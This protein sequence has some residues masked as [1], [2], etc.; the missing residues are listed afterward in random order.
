M[1]SGLGVFGGRGRCHPFWTDFSECMSKADVPSDCKEMR[2]DYFECLHHRK[3]FIGTVKH[4]RVADYK[5]PHPPKGPIVLQDH[6]NPMR[7][8]NIWI[9]HIGDYDEG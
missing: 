2:E 4:K 7:F 9:R 1:A 6:G 8:R 5:S 3:E